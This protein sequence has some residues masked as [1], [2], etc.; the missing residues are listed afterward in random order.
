MALVPY[1]MPQEDGSACSI[2]REASLSSE[3]MVDG[4][5]DGDRSSPPLHVIE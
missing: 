1:Q 3:P 4:R 2:E 5:R